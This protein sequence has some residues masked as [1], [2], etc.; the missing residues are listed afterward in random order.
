VSATP[1]RL[2]V[3]YWPARTATAW[4]S[5]FDAGEVAEDFAR[6]AAAGMDSVRFFLK[7]ED[8]QPEPATANPEM[9]ERL[10]TV[11]DAA[12]TAGLTIMPTLFTGHMSGVDWIPAWAL[13]GTDRDDRFRVVSGGRVVEAKLRNWYSDPEM[14]EAQAFLAGEAARALAAHQGLLAWDLGNENSNCVIPPDT[15]RGRR[16]LGRMTES[17]R[18]ADPAAQITIGI[19][20]EDLEENRNLGP[21]EAAEACDFL[22]MHGYPIYAQWAEGRTDSSLVPFL[23]EITRWLGNGADVLFSEFGLPTYL[24][25]DPAG[26]RDAVRSPMLV[27]EADAARY[28]GAV[29]RGLQEA[30]TLGAML[31][32]FAD[33]DRATWSAP[34]LDLSVHERSFG[35]WRADG[36][37]KASVADVAG[38]AGTSRLPVPDH[39]WIDIEPEEYWQ[40]P[41]LQLPRLYGRYRSFPRSRP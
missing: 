32:C 30:G 28:T 18:A 26:E 15:A 9:L 31:W 6:I 17:V 39:E 4:W 41:S 33:Y 7:W 12:A 24:P 13:G 38:F 35:L 34:P 10:V 16:W 8:F 20:M 14:V 25:G 22:T 21:A 37:A 27:T 2:G 23:A 1:F 19:H 36:S 5:M 3:N 11:A 29:L 40:R